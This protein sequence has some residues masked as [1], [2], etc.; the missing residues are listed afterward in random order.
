M[1]S[2]IPYIQIIS[3][4][5]PY[6]CS[7]S[8]D[9]TLVT[10]PPKN[11]LETII[12]S[13]FGKEKICYSCKED[14]IDIYNNLVNDIESCLKPIKILNTDIIKHI[15]SYLFHDY[16]SVVHR[17]KSNNLL[18]EFNEANRINSGFY[19]YETMILCNKCFHKG[20]MLSLLRNNNIPRMRKDA[21]LFIINPE[22]NEEKE[23]NISFGK[24]FYPKTFTI[25]YLRNFPIIKNGIVYVSEK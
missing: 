20:I 2:P 6:V 15:C 17:R 14:C 25:T 21:V 7:K 4:V 23:I 12:M 8:L 22:N 19:W 11:I 18:E 10:L 5:S 9:A 24:N 3:S 16:H 13:L 1:L